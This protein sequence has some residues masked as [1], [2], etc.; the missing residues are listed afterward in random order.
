M[1]IYI[2]HKSKLTFIPPVISEIKLLS[3]LGY[4]VTVIDEGITDYWKKYFD[5]IGVNYVEILP[6]NMNLFMKAYSYLNFRKKVFCYLKSHNVDKS[7]SILWIE[8]AQTIFA[9][10]AKLLKY[11]FVLQIS[12]LHEEIKYQFKATQKVVH[13]AKV[14]V[15]PEYNRALIF[16]AMH[17]IKKKP[18]I[19]PNKPYFIPSQDELAKSASEYKEYCDYFTSNKVIL[20]Q[21]IINDERNLTSFVKAVKSFQG[22]Y[23][24]VLM[25]KD[26][27][28]VERY[29]KI[30]PSIVHISFIPA[31]HYL[32]MTSLCHIGIVMYKPECLNTIY[33]APNKTFEY[34]SFGKPML[35]N[36]IP[37]LKVID[38]NKMGSTVDESCETNIVEAIK[39][40]EQNYS[41]CSSNSKKY[42]ENTDNKEVIKRIIDIA[43]I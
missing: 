1:K 5:E 41:Q 8:G 37:G 43:S 2:I 39:W 26:C 15:L 23:K 27:G 12:E 30:D 24:L 21:G 25:G 42:F 7:T 3:E 18:I 28:L 6:N 20:Y 19:L 34:A 13:D 9:L 11:R 40:I 4:E 22:E 14:V 36:D 16:Q 10:G 31:P 17:K 35:G 29:K 32:I 38:D 33:C